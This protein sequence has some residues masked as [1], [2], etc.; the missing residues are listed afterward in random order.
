MSRWVSSLQSAMDWW[1]QLLVGL[2][3][4]TPVWAE[5]KLLNVCMKAKHHKQE[6]SPEDQLYEEVKRPDQVRAGRQAALAGQGRVTNARMISEPS[7][8]LTHLVP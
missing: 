2:W 1:W 8:T 6:P 5:D 7:S 4:V 3:I